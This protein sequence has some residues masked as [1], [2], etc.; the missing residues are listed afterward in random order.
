M[1]DRNQDFTCLSW[2]IHRCRGNDG[3]VDPARTLATLRAEMPVGDI[4]ALILQEADEEVPPHRGL[5]DI[6]AVEAGTG[7]RYIHTNPAHRWS[8][9]SHGFLG[10]IIFVRPDVHVDRITLLDLPGRC[11]RGAVIADLTRDGQ[12]FRLVGMHL[13]LMQAL[14]WAQLRTICQYMFRKPRQ[15]AILIGDMNEWRPWGGFA[16]SKRFLSTDLR[17]PVKPTF[18]INRPFLP[19]DRVLTTAPAQVRSSEVIDGPGVRMTSDHRPLLAHI[20]LGH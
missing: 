8:D 5:L 4:D 1:P 6:A 10:T 3:K 20:N 12:E 2:N 17:G 18:P 13:S 14:R 19:L 15:P 9:G 7:L 16:L 11:H